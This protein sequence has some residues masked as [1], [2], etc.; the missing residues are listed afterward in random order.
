M[1][2][3]IG[4]H[5]QTA[6]I[7]FFPIIFIIEFFGGKLLILLLQTVFL[8]RKL[9]LLVRYL[10]IIQISLHLRRIHQLN[11]RILIRGFTKL[12]DRYIQLIPVI[13]QLIKKL[14]LDFLIFLI[15]NI[16][17]VGEL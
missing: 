14:C 8:R 16:L 12:P 3:L 10:F 9:L 13:H 6:H 5:I 7:P 17:I 2:K 1:L 11:H 15:K 4:F